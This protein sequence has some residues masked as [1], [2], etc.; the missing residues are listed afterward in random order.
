MIN[1]CQEPFNMSSIITIQA[2]LASPS[3]SDDED[4]ANT[5]ESPLQPFAEKEE[6]PFMQINAIEP[7]SPSYEP[8]S[9]A[10]DNSI[11]RLTWPQFSPQ[12]RIENKPMEYTALVGSRPIDPRLA[13]DSRTI[14]RRDTDDDSFPRLVRSRAE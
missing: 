6:S 10:E 13:V 4:N 7:H 1:D 3:T 8:A 12:P 11:P 14:R 9:P 2:V 5:P